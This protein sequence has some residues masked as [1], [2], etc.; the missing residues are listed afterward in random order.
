MRE[1][2]RTVMNGWI[3]LPVVILAWL[4]V[5]SSIIRGGII[6]S[7][8]DVGG[9]GLIILGILLIPTAILLTAGM[10]SLQPN[11][12][13]VLVLFGMYVGSVKKDGLHWTNPFSVHRGGWES[14][15]EGKEVKAVTRTRS[16]YR[17]SLR[18]RNFQT[19]PLKVNDQRGNPIEIAAVVVW[20]VLDTAKALFDVDEYE[21][22]VRIQSETAVRH[23]ATSY[24]YDHTASE[25]DTDE[26]TLRANTDEVSVALQHELQARLEKAG[27]QIE[28]ARLTHLP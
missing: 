28:E 13:Q 24:P 20:R 19:E 2:E 22:Y 14:V 7:Q 27:V 12:A 16:K 25:E 3:M 9:V 5:P 23:V 18:A 15:K 11:E 6:I 21:H 8:G 1:Q 17:V 10:F 4:G 26:L